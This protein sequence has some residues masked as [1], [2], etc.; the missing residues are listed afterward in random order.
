MNSLTAKKDENLLKF[1]NAN[2]ELRTCVDELVQIAADRDDNI[3]IADEAEEKI[4]K[5][6]RELGKATL[7][8]WAESRSQ[9]VEALLKTDSEVRS[10]GKKLWWRSTFDVIEVEE[11]L[12]RKGR[13][14]LRGF[15]KQAQVSCR[16]L[17]K[18]LQRAVTDFGAELPFAQAQLRL[19]E[20]YGIEVP[21]SGIREVT[22]QHGKAMHEQQ[23]LNCEWPDTDGVRHVI[24]QTDG[25][26]VP[27]VTVDS[28]VSDKRKD[29]VLNWQE[30][31]LTIA[32]AQQSLKVHYGG[33]F[34]GG[35]EETGRQ[36]YDCARRADFG[37]GTQL[38]AVGDGAVWIRN[39]VEEKFGSNGSYLVDFMHLC[40][41]L[42]AAAPSCASDV[43]A[44]LSQQKQRL[45]ANQAVQVVEAL[46]AHIEAPSV[47]DED[48][49]V[50]RAH[51]YLRKR[52]DQVDYQGAAEKDLPI[53]SGE[54]ESAHRYVIQ[55]R[56]KRPGAWWSADNVDNMLALRLC[57]ANEQWE[58]YWEGGNRKTA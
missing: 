52:L 3:Q 15:S 58:A 5:K 25:S 28:Q 6:I 31:R 27:V 22:E 29:K 39:Q 45:K 9:H 36:L 11:R 21:V 51:R 40:E 54:I 47:A 17:S 4:I 35:V 14:L 46:M 23:E 19:R 16:G 10:A 48:A 12:F 53:G 2:P 8:S 20:H 32:H 34:S 37:R 30:I 44:W 56:L 41:Y 43:S 18:P 55:A 33:N 7:G 1:L 42:S 24:A 57:R 26:M 13:H 50:R 38:H 49:P